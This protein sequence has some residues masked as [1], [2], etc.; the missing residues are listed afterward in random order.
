VPSKN[1][2][3]LSARTACTAAGQTALLMYDAEEALLYGVWSAQSKV[4]PPPAALAPA[5][6]AAVVRTSTALAAC[7]LLPAA[8]CQACILQAVS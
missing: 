5:A 3:S 2:H 8:C 6:P 4:P 1:L 7:C